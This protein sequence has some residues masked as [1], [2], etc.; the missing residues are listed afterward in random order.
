M[1]LVVLLFGI[2]QDKPFQKMAEE[3]SEVF[4]FVTKETAEDSVFAVPFSG[5]A[6]S[7]SLVAHR[8]VYAGFG[9]P[10]NERYFKDYKKRESRMFGNFS[11]RVEAGGAWIGESM[12]RVY[13][14]RG[15]L[16][17]VVYAKD[18]KLDY[19]MVES[20]HSKKF[21]QHTPVFKGKDYLI[22]R[23]LDLK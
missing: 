23:V 13:R 14:S 16:D 1:F 20:Q 9:F 8:A 18:E 15:P 19:V 11:E 10:F 7:L 3:A 5:F 2:E 12:A 6:R 22:F 4:E 21:A 17:F